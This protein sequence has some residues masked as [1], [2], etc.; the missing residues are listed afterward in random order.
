MP[1]PLLL[2]IATAALLAVP[3]VAMAATK[4]GITPTAPKA[5]K[6]IAVGKRPTLKGR[7]SGSGQIYI[8]VCKNKKKDK[9]GIICSSAAK[10]EAIQ[11]AKRSGGKFSA[12]MKFFDFP[13]FWLNSP[14][15]YYW[16][17]HRIACEGGD[18]SDCRQEGPIVR[19]K[20]G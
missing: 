10:A 18:I 11:K 1:R 16:Q 15:T 19:F 2:L 14:G 4:N 8:H 6:T 7:V 3:T 17:A 12:K 9:D 13:E 5:G 20:V